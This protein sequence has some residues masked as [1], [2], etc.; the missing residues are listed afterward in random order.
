MGPQG[1]DQLLV[2]GLL[3]RVLLGSQ[4][5]RDLRARALHKMAQS[6]HRLDGVDGGV[7]H[8]ARHAAKARQEV[9]P[10]LLE[11]LARSQF[12]FGL[13]R[14]GRRRGCGFLKLGLTMNGHGRFIAAAGRSAPRTPSAARDHCMRLRVKHGQNVESPFLRG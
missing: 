8:G 1:P 3:V 13:L 11:G 7:D 10:R 4:L 5:A 14:L 12:L 6:A 2:L 9:L